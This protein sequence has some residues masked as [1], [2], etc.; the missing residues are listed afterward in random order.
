LTF[1]GALRI[2]GRYEPESLKKLDTWLG[3][4][5]LTA[6]AV[7]L[8]ASAGAA[9]GP[10]AL[11]APIWAWVDQKNE[12]TGLL[13]K[14]VGRLANSL[15]RTGGRERRELIQAAHTVVVA[16]AFFEVF[17]EY[18][19]SEREREISLTK[20]E[21]KLL[22]FE[23]KSLLEHIYDNT[24]P[25]P[26]PTRGFEENLVDV[27]VWFVDLAVR[28]QEFLRGLVIRESRS[29]DLGALPE[30]ATERYRTL[31]LRLSVSVPEFQIWAFL[32]EH[33]ATRAAVEMTRSEVVDALTVG[34]AALSQLEALLSS[35]PRNQSMQQ[36]LGLVVSR[37]NLASLT[38]PIAS[39]GPQEGSVPL[40]F[41]TIER[42]F[43]APRYRIAEMQSDSHPA[44]E[45][46]WDDFDVQ[47]SLDLTL[48][49]FVLGS[50]STRRP[51][52]LL[53]HPG[54]G[55]SMLTKIMAARLP[56][57]EYMVV[58]VPL[59]AVG[60]N[61]PVI[62]Q[63]QQA[64][65]LATNRRVEWARLSD[66]CVNSIRV[67]ILDGLD[68]LLQS[69][70]TDRTGYLQDIVRFQEIE[71]EQDRP[72]IVIVTSRIVVADRV[73]VPRGSTMIKL[74]EFDDRQ[75]QVWL[76]TW[77]EANRSA[78][79][80]DKMQPLTFDEAM[81]QREL[82]RQPLLLLMLAVYA[83]DPR[84]PR[85]ARAS[86]TTA[87]YGHLL[88]SFARREVL[89]DETVSAQSPEFT[90]LVDRQL[91]RLSIAALAM[92]NRG[93]QFV[94]ETQLG[95]D[96]SVLAPRASADVEA[97]EL[98]QRLLGEFFFVHSSEATLIGA[99]G[100]AGIESA[101][102]K[103]AR[104]TYEF[105]HATFGEYLVAHRVMETLRD[106]AEVAFAGSR[107]REP[108]DDLI[109][110]L[111]SHQ[112]LA[113]R[114][115]TVSF[116]LELFRDLESPEQNNIVALLS[117]LALGYRQ[118]HGSDRYAEYRPLP[119]DTLRELARYSANIFLLRAAFGSLG[120][121]MEFFGA[122]ADARRLW[123]STVNLWRAGLD[124]DGWK[125]MLASIVRDGDDLVLGTEAPDFGP[126]LTEF[127]YARLVDDP[128]LA[129]RFR[130]GV[131]I[132]DGVA[133][134]DGEDWASSMLSW[135]IPA[136]AGIDVHP[137]PSRPPVD[138][139]PGGRAVARHI[140]VLL[141]SRRADRRM[142]SS[143]IEIYLDL[144]SPTTVDVY[145]LAVSIA[146]HPGL[147]SEIGRLN[148]PQLF[149]NGDVHLTHELLTSIGSD[150]S[151]PGQEP[152]TREDLDLLR[153]LADTILQPGSELPQSA[154]YVRTVMWNLITAIR[155]R[156]DEKY[157]PPATDVRLEEGGTAAMGDLSD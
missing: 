97:G 40:T 89:K 46:W 11:I 43:V 100:G 111:L 90:E 52:L 147:L 142:V 151:S 127:Q 117:S 145:A 146:D 113:V 128:L 73:D 150:T 87:L 14:L 32:G 143:L 131:A 157:T 67:V 105:L 13:G 119:H 129:T 10:L 84:S 50:E 99:G 5:I 102:L 156:D 83:A 22:A 94:N 152:T 148:D 27:Q 51:L 144:V 24:L 95:S 114:Q 17:N 118:R 88:E 35:M 133:F 25:I 124:S 68:E 31:Y 121:P 60:A 39:T 138:D 21:K 70:N 110:A 98:G 12:A 61:A 80:E 63:L 72:V 19:G 48:A 8:A 86:S 74:E 56:T 45:R 107:K 33:A 78:I 92:F 134:Y 125:S 116:L 28:M 36:D 53:G 122:G 76:D 109:F 30:L 69:T 103:V 104:R 85:L 58:R 3:G 37:A 79:S 65:D 136:I 106:A 15:D 135:L 153:T 140:A 132:H 139:P 101:R 49:G 57:T 66:Q 123:Q 26:S 20:T 34:S 16:A 42:A 29:I 9:L 141:R 120:S 82:A 38:Q 155:S 41:P 6:G 71:A 54:A 62:D 47:D 96:L 126:E 2:L 93:V 44:D 115:S 23:T 112:P 81:Y 91:E 108:E 75:V 130:L 59:R 4:A 77:S 18:I 137:V 154:A 7:S 64:L 55:K 149:R 1:E